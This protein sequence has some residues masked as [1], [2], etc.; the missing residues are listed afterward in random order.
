MSRV[1]GARNLHVLLDNLLAAAG[2]QGI[3]RTRGCDTLGSAVLRSRAS[4]KRQQRL[5]PL[6]IF[7]RVC[8]LSRPSSLDVSSG[9]RVL[10]GVGSM[11][12]G[13]FG[14]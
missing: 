3:T 2:E 9:L 6:S 14:I 4:W 5:R 1:L 11:V 10:Q 8:F 12:S 13:F 7:S